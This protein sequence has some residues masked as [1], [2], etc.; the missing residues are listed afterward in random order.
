MVRKYSVLSNNKFA[1]KSSDTQI[2]CLKDEIDNKILIGEEDDT[3]SDNENQINPKN[4]YYTGRK[5]TP[6]SGESSATN[7]TVV[8]NVIDTDL[9]NV[10]SRPNLGIL[11]SYIALEDS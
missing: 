5:V 11:P 6:E 9:L 3:K 1:K 8:D 7:T 4:R 2:P 10:R